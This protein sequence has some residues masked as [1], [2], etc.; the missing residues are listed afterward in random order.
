VYLLI[1]HSS[2]C[3]NTRYNLSTS[4]NVTIKKLSQPLV[5]VIFEWGQV[6]VCRLEFFDYV[7][8]CIDSPAV[9]INQ[10][11]RVVNLVIQ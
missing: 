4:K 11:S 2:S 3:R 6:D 7:V 1:N 10:Q 8:Q 9:G 5:G